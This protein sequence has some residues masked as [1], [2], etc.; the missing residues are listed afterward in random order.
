MSLG[1]LRTVAAAMEIL[2]AAFSRQAAAQ[3]ATAADFGEQAAAL[4]TAGRAR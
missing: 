1:E 4:V 2:A 3:A